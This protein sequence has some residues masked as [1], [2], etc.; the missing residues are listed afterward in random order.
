MDPSFAIQNQKANENNPKCSECIKLIEVVFFSQ[1]DEL[2]LPVRSKKSPF[3]GLWCVV[4][5]LV[6]FLSGLI[7]ASVCLYRYYFS[8]QVR[9]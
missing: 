1:E 7:M 5:G 4:L 8:P 9:R 3:S 2:V 6:I